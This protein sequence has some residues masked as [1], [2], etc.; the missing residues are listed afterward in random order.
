M[1]SFREC[2]RLKCPMWGF[3][4]SVTCVEC[5]SFAPTQGIQHVHHC[6]IFKL[7]YV[8][9]WLIDRLPGLTVCGSRRFHFPTLLRSY[10]NGSYNYLLCPETTRQI[11]ILCSNVWQEKLLTITKRA[12]VFSS[13]SFTFPSLPKC[14]QQKRLYTRLVLILKPFDKE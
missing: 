3:I 5:E 1:C 4:C 13:P 10:L 2:D 8:P 11:I 7:S 6:S 9:P 12:A 14:P